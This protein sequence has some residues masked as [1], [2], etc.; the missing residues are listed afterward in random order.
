MTRWAWVVAILYLLV[1]VAVT[2][3]WLALFVHPAGSLEQAA[4]GLPVVALLGLGG[5]DV[6]L[7]GGLTRG[8]CSSNELSKHR[9]STPDRALRGFSIHDGNPCA[10]IHRDVFRNG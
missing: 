7:P 1:L 8:S 9:A 10:W 4:E 6:P 3:P 5:R 2:C